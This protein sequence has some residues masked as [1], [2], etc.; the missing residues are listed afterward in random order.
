MPI[1]PSILRASGTSPASAQ[2]RRRRGRALMSSAIAAVAVTASLAVA[3]PAQASQQIMLGSAGDAAAMS[4][5]TGEPMAVHTYRY[6]SQ[7]VPTGVQ[8]ITVRVP[9]ASWRQVANAGPGSSIYND[10]VRWA[11]TL[12]ARGDRVMLAYH[13][14]PEAG[15]S[16]NFGSPADFVAAFRHVASIF[17]AQGASNVVMTWQLTA[18][19]FRVKPSDRRYYMNWYPGD[20]YVDNIGIDGYNAGNCYGRHEWRGM[21]EILSGVMPFAAARHKPVSLQEFAAPPDSR[22]AQWLQGVHQYLAQHKDVITAAF[23]F[24]TGTPGSCDWRL[25]TSPEF[26]AYGDMARDASSFRV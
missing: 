4:R 1:S 19:A 23:Y 7:S 13:H 25:K 15:G 8:S 24:N 26:K 22:R 20:Q 17:R 12:K 14:E 5:G 9:N 10:I 3:T 11:Q 21:D 2:G 18:F 6:F 16:R